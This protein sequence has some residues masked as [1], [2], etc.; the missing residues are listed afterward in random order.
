[1]ANTIDIVIQAHDRAS[2]QLAAVGN[3]AERLS[4][5]LRKMR[6]PLLGVTAAIGGLGFFAVKTFAAFEQQMA[7]VG[8]VSK[9]TSDELVMLTDIAKEMGRTTQ[10]TA[11]QAAEA[12]TFMSM[13]GMDVATQMEALPKVLQLAAAG[14]LDLGAAADIVTN[15]MAG[16]GLEASELTK[17][18]DVL[19]TA[20]TNANTDLTQLGQAFKMAGPVAKAAGLSFEETTAALAVMGNAGF[21]GTM[22]GTALRGA[23]SRLL[24]PTGA[25]AKTIERL[26]LTVTDSQ[27]KFLPLVDIIGQLERSGLSAGDAM[28]IFGQRAGPAMLALVS[29][30]SGALSDLVGKMEESGGIAEEI[31]AK[32]LDTLQGSFL[33]LKSAVEGV[34][35]EIGTAL[36][37][38]LR[39]IAGKLQEVA[40]VIAGLNPLVLKAGVVVLALVA[41]LA[42]LGLIL[43]PIIA[44]FGVLATIIGA[45]FSPITLIAVAIVGAVAL[46]ILALTRWR[47]GTKEV[48]SVI[49]DLAFLAASGWAKAFDFLVSMIIGGVSK[50]LGAFSGLLRFLGQDEMAD[51]IDGWQD[52]IKGFELGASKALIKVK[53][54]LKDLAD[55]GIDKAGESLDVLQNELK[56][57]IKG[58]DDSTDSM[59]AFEGALGRVINT[60]KDMTDTM[61]KGLK[62][63]KEQVENTTDSV[64]ELTES[65]LRGKEA[66][67]GWGPMFAHPTLGYSSAVA[68]PGSGVMV[69]E[70]IYREDIPGQ[71]YIAGYHP[72]TDEELHEQIRKANEESRAGVS[73]G[74]SK[75]ANTY[76][77]FLGIDGKEIASTLDPYNGDAANS[78]SNVR[79]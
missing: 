8:A 73:G 63:T 16:F 72:A 32:Q 15:V 65:L 36:A 71:R 54:T 6:G 44:G 58:I 40:S 1:M 61:S 28:T 26:G 60:S 30:G 25:A 49:I 33:L 35:I 14:G 64:D 53:D 21:Q 24:N 34:F 70:P 12:L 20:F 78:E 9:A 43:P 31:A 56:I 74:P 75:E 29:Q 2:K 57:F 59:E 42:V 22:A 45:L 3:R 76:N 4:D 69:G 10:F 67:T 13:A 37:P 27:G 18:N 52:S 41:A 55:K 11:S 46:I 62:G 50:I 48:V 66:S 7:R 38:A 77:I 19:T 23:I 47:E 5:K 17:A 39:S 68:G 79:S 51:A